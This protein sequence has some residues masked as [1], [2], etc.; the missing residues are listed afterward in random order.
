M[1][2]NILTTCPQEISF[3]QIEEASPMKFNVKTL[4]FAIGVPPATKAMF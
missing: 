4:A 2:L 3:P 1:A